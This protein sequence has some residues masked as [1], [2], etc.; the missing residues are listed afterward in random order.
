MNDVALFYTMVSIIV[1]YVGLIFWKFGILKSISQSYYE[2]P[3]IWKPIFTLAMWGF[4][5]PAMLIGTPLTGL[6]FFASAGIMFVGA[7]AAFNDKEITRP[8]HFIGAGTGVILSQLAIGLIFGFW[9]INLIFGI[10]SILLILFNKK[11][12]GTYLLWIEILAIISI[13]ILYGII[14]F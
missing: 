12:N 6:L 4:A 3:K 11:I 7:A 8:V 9:Q 5:F 10:S 14:I 1:G 2:L 13:C